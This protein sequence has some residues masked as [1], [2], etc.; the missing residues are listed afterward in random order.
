M[1]ND[2]YSFCTPHLTLGEQILWK[3]KAQQGNMLTLYDLWVIPFSVF[4][5]GMVVRIGCNVLSSENGILAL[6]FLLLFLAVG[7]YLMFGRFILTKLIRE[8]TLYVITNKKIIRKRANRVRT[9]DIFAYPRMKTRVCK[10][11]NGYI[12]LLTNARSFSYAFHIPTEP[13]FPDGMGVGYFVL[14]N[15]PEVEWVE[16][17]LTDIRTPKG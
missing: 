17:I 5:T 13:L 2:D 7:L 1:M 6:P 11:S 3:G 10:D 9:V 16:K 14:E 4:W 12:M 8:H 15:I